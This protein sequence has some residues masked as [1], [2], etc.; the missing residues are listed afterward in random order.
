MKR[1]LIPVALL[2]VSGILMAALPVPLLPLFIT[3]FILGFLCLIWNRANRVL[4]CALLVLAGWL[5]LAEHT[6]ILSP[7]DLRIQF[8]HGDELVTVR[9]RPQ[10]NTLSPGPRNKK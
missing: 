3:A 5:N 4:L 2:Y 1:P 6:A 7:H 10:R 9:V 8:T